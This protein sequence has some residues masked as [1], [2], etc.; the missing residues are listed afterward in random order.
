MPLLPEPT[1]MK[2]KILF[3]AKTTTE[4]INRK[5]VIT[6]TQ[7]WYSGLAKDFK[8]KLIEVEMIDDRQG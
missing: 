3:Q 8:K 1:Q 7:I 6:K 2:D 4:G 5:L